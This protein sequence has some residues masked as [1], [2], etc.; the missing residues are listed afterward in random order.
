MPNRIIKES[1]CTSDTLDELT[2]F[3]EAVF[4]R[5]IVNCDDY[6]RFDGRL[7]VVKNKLFP[8]KE[9]ITIKS[10]SD[11]INKLSTVGLVILYEYE[12][13]PYMQLVTWAKHQQVRAKKSKYPAYD[14]SCCNLISGDIKCPRNPIQSESNPIQIQSN[15]RTGF[16]EFWAAYPKKKAKGDAEKAWKGV[17]TDLSVILSALERQKQSIDWQKDGGKYIP[18]PASWLRA[19]RWEDTDPDPP[20]PSEP[21]IHKAPPEWGY[22]PNADFLERLGVEF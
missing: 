16:D 14:A 20:T 15:T 4:Y 9:N 2:W 10:V 12:D 6:G 19:K 13:K 22:D 8:L 18:Y 7:A 21:E 1:I 3:E 5:L 17:K 11:A